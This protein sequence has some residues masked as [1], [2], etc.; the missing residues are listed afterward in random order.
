[1]HR[2]GI[3]YDTGV[4]P[5]GDRLSR[6]SFDSAQ[7]RREME[8]IAHDLHC[9]AVRITGGDSSRVALAAEYALAVGLEVWFAPFPCNMTADELV[10]YFVASAQLAEQLRRRSPR[11]VFVLGCEMTLFNSGFVPGGSVLERMQTMTNPALLANQ[12]V[13]PDELQQRFNAFLERAAA[14]VRRDFA[15][16]VTYA[17]APWENVDWS[18]F[19]IVGVDHYRDAGNRNSYREQL[20]AYFAYERP[21]VVTEFGCCTYRDAP[22]RGAMGWAIVDRAAQPPRLTEDVVRDEQAQADYLVEL[23]DVLDEEGVDGA[24][25]FTFAAFD[26]P[27]HADPR[28]DLDCASYGVVK[29]LDGPP[30]ETYPGMPW[31]PKR[32]FHAL[33]KYY[34]H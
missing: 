29:I 18:Q 30:G 1:M 14:A 21:V 4:A 24:F 34:A 15:G 31:E 13:S 16:P 27:Y 20:R 8:T 32:S 10:P 28:Y 23:L 33:A 22:D 9:T 25:W 3:N 5:Y 17:S 7:V 19:D 11:V 26:N 2:K 12:N 6:E